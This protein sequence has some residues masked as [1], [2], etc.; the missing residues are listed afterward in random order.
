MNADCGP[1]AGLSLKVADG[2]L[3][4]EQAEWLDGHLRECAACRERQQR[5]LRMDGELIEYG[6]WCEEPA[7]FRAVRRTRWIPAAAAAAAAAVLLGIAV[8]RPAPPPANPSQSPEPERFVPVPYVLPLQPGESAQVMRMEVPV[9]ALIA[10]GYDVGLADPAINVPAEVLVG[11]DG[12]VHA[13]RLLS[14]VA[15]N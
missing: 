13:V 2:D 6:A 12:R 8:L 9:A 5:F 14:N 10:A 15:L 1:A 4:P 3:T 11:E 7:A